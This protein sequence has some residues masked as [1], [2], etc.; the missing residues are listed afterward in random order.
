MLEDPASNLN[1]AS[2]PVP[3][4]CHIYIPLPILDV[5]GCCGDW[6]AA[7]WAGTAV[8]VAGARLKWLAD[9]GVE[10]KRKGR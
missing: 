6:S 9:A 4:N 2:I 7:V 1:L 8:G 5:G 3:P 10:R